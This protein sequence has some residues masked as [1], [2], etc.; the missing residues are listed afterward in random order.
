MESDGFD[1]EIAQRIIVSQS[2]RINIEKIFHL[3]NGMLIENIIKIT[4]GRIRL[5][6]ILAISK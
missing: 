3:E 2:N 1:E 4:V 6:I 5:Q